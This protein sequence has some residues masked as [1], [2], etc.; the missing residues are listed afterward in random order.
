MMH[1]RI[2]PRDQVFVKAYGF[3]SLAKYMSKDLGKSITKSLSGKCI[4][5]ILIMLKEL[6]QMHLKLLQK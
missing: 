6:L 4:K 3:L 5:S 2:E 1:H